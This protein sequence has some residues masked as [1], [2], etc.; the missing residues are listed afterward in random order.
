LGAEAQAKD[1]SNFDHVDPLGHA[2]PHEAKETQ[3][4]GQSETNKRMGGGI[5]R[6]VNTDFTVVN[7]VFA[8][9]PKCSRCRKKGVHV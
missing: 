6:H 7:R 1:F 4:T 9:G 3:D 2:A 8:K 5:L